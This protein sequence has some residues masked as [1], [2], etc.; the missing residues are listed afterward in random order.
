MALT[1]GRRPLRVAEDIKAFL[2]RALVT[3]LADARLQLLVVTRVEV[4]A[5]LSVA[6]V[7]VR[8]LADVAGGLSRDAVLKCLRRAAPR[9]RRELAARLKLRRV[10][11]LR[12][13]YDIGV[14]ARERVEELLEEIAQERK[15]DHCTDD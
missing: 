13:Q 15:E 14:D 8:S 3:E 12:F 9:L 6:W 4:P 2:A 7:Y 11:E 5:D 10:P 1:E